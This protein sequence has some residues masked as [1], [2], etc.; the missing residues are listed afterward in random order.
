MMKKLLSLICTCCLILALAVPTSAAEAGSP[1]VEVLDIA[2]ANNSGSNTFAFNNSGSVTYPLGLKTIVSHID[3]TVIVAGEAPTAV[4]IDR[5]NG[6]TA[7]LTVQKIYGSMYRIYGGVGGYV[8]SDIKLDFESN[9][10]SSCEVLSMK[11]AST[12]ITHYVPSMTFDYVFGA[13]VTDFLSK[14]SF[15]V[16]VD[17]V[18]EFEYGI[19]TDY[20]IMPI[21]S[22]WKSYDFLEFTVS[23]YYA[24]ITAVSATLAGDI[25]PVTVSYLDAE[26]DGAVTGGAGTTGYTYPD[27]YATILVDL[28]GVNRSVSSNPEIYINGNWNLGSGMEFQFL[29]VRG[30]VEV[31]DKTGVLYW[32]DRFTTFMTDLF[33]G[34]SSPSDDFQNEATEQG[35][36]MDDLN[37]ELHNATNPP[38]ENID[39][40]IS[41]Y[42]GADDMAAVTGEFSQITNDP[43]IL[44]I[45]MLSL[46]VALVAYILYGKR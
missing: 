28:R 27:L 6:N 7:A 29:Y 16:T 18:V 15:S 24:D 11:V 31:A 3:A 26:P 1:W 5:G 43:L 44:Q 30:Y 14:D 40:D 42:V 33:K 13:N 32:W 38:L 8:L 9:G 21:V 39:T 37:D 25:L 41:D 10:Y 35:S 36:Q 22:D 46:T 17:P 23:T 4:Y 2:T 19:S 12:A 45:T 34:D 20:C